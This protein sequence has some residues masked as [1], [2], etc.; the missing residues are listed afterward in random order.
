MFYRIYLMGNKVCCEESRTNQPTLEYV[1]PEVVSRS[2][3]EVKE[4]VVRLASRTR[5]TSMRRLKCSN[6][7]HRP[8]THTTRSVHD[9][10]LR[11]FRKGNRR[12]GERSCK[13]IRRGRLCGRYGRGS[14]LIRQFGQRPNGFGRMYKPNGSMYVGYF[15][16]GRAQGQGAYIF[17][18][19]SYY[20][21]E[22]N[23]NVA[24]GIEGY[25]RSDRMTYEGGFR[26]NKFDGKGY[27]KG[28]DYEFEGFYVDGRREKG[29]LNWNA[30]NG[31]YRYEGE[32]NEYNQF[33][34]K[35][36][37]PA[38]QATSP[39][40]TVA[41]RAP[42]PT[43]R[44]KATGSTSRRTAPSTRGPTSTA[45]ARVTAPSSTATAASPTRDR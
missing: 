28:S 45:T 20:K 5:R 23:H 30:E 42:S 4:V 19:G 22:F 27:E 25:Y 29:I 38:M 7:R 16:Q 41:T 43:A 13:K 8:A 11:V 39:S 9:R 33:D 40:P 35:G 12:A 34:G 36:T 24:E 44:R 14:T 10:S 6:C 32:F 17:E 37:P 21:G 18:D 15:E 31:K 1:E 2:R 3:M 26:N